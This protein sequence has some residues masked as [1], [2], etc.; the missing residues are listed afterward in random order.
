M[1]LKTNFDVDIDFRTDFNPLTVFTQAVP[2]SR[3]D[4]DI[5]VKHQVG[6]YLQGMP[7]DPISKLSAI[8]FEEAEEIGFIKIDMLHLN[9]LNYFE[10]KHEIRSLLKREPDWN[11]LK[12]PDVV[13]QLFQIKKH[14][15]LVT[16]IRPKSVQELAD[17]I[18]LIRPGKRNLL[19]M[20]LKDREVVRNKILY[21]KPI[22]DANYFKKSHAISY[23]FVIILQ[24]HLIKNGII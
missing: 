9:I 15:E 6:I 2:A 5:L 3:V 4:K 21:I 14:F 18:A 13:V 23:A 22:N 8:P 1:N 11:L 24:L 12:D 19:D 20:Y 10:N 16:K 7:V 17:T